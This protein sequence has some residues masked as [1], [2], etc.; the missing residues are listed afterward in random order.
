[1]CE[2][3]E[4][5]SKTKAGPDEKEIGGRGRRARTSYRRIRGSGRGCPC[6]R[7]TVSIDLD[8]LMIHTC[9]SNPK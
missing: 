8:D 9:V 4:G 1:M 7:M 5:C 3:E 2:E 6:L